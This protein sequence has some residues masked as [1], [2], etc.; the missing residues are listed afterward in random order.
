MLTS[1]IDRF[2]ASLQLK[3]VSRILFNMPLYAVI[4]AVEKEAPLG[5]VRQLLGDSLIRIS[6]CFLLDTD[7]VSYYSLSILHSVFIM[8]ALL[9]HM[10]RVHLRLSMQANGP[11]TLV[12]LSRRCMG[13]NLFASWKIGTYFGNLGYPSSPWAKS[14]L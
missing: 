11:Q 6:Q 13:S 12:Y 14:N 5:R 1:S 7:T 4:R 2:L 9:I 10:R 3:W 8:H